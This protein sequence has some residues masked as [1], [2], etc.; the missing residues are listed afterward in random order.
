M[1]NNNDTRKRTRPNNVFEV[2]LYDEMA[3]ETEKAVLDILAKTPFNKI[4]V[5]VSIYKSR[6]DPNTPCDDTR[7]ITAGY[8]KKYDPETKKF[9]IVIFNRLCEIVA[10][11]DNPV[12]DIA[13]TEYNGNFGTITKLIVAGVVKREDQELADE[14]VAE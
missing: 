9:T 5:P 1:K 10:A 7:V 4:S 13:H 11:I 12:M 6:V 8:V 3:E 2:P 14:D